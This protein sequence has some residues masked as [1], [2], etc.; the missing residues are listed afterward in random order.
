MYLIFKIVLK[1][2]NNL[3]EKLLEMGDHDGP[4]VSS[5]YQIREGSYIFLIY[6]YKV[7]E[8]VSLLSISDVHLLDIC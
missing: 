3:F 4:R 2:F 8:N 6:E 1:P 7:G 5:L